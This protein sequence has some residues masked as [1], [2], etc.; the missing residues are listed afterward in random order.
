[1][2]YRDPDHDIQYVEVD[3]NSI[4]HVAIKSFSKMRW[5]HHYDDNAKKFVCLMVMS[6]FLDFKY[7][8]N[9]DLCMFLNI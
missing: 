7:K 5:L 9:I 8:V 4:I 6:R 3:N 1:M 2:I